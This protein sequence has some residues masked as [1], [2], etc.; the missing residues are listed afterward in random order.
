MATHSVLSE[1]R[2]KFA[3]SVSKPDAEVRLYDAKVPA[4]LLWRRPRGTNRWYVFLRAGG[5]MRR[6]PVGDVSTWPTVSVEEARKL[7]VQIVSDLAKGADPVKA[8]AEKRALARGGRAPF[9]DAL[10]RHLANLKKRGC[11]APHIA[12][13]SRVVKAAIESGIKDL[14]APNVATKAATFLD[15]LDVSDQTRH[16]YRVHLIAVGKS[17]VRWYPPEVLPREPFMALSGEGAIMPPPPVFQPNECCSLVSDKALSLIDDGGRLWAFLLYSGCRYKEAAFARWDRLNLDRATFGV[18]PP[19]AVEHAAGERVKRNK[20][21]TVSLQSEL[22]DLLR[23]WHPG[24]KKGDGFVFPEKWRTQNYRY[25]V[26][27][28]R[29]HLVSLEIKLDGRRIH[30]LRHSHACLAIACGEDSLRLRLSMGHAGEEMAEHYAS[31]AMRWRGQLA[32][33]D[34]VFKLRDPKEVERIACET[35]DRKAVG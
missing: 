17:A 31:Q 13:L 11:S 8:K 32:K 35:G 23:T 5:R 9:S 28:F 12:E 30:A 3:L 26:E 21:R 18:I 20:S 27:D 15:K 29:R 1:S 14:A 33:W 10:D 2:I 7:A 34:G 24:E 16:R 25:T 4:L 19:S 6:V 22:I